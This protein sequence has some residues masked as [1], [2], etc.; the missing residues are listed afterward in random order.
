MFKFYLFLAVVF[1]S[2]SPVRADG[3][4]PAAPIPQ[5]DGDLMP[6]PVDL[7]QLTP[8]PLPGAPVKQEDS[9][10]TIPAA[11]E[12]LAPTATPTP[13]ISSAKKQI[14][15]P[16]VTPMAVPAVTTVE[17][18]VIS[19]PAAASTDAATGGLLD[20]F[21]V[22]EGLKW[23]YDYLKAAPGAG[24]KTRLVECMGSETMANGT[25]RAKFKTTEDGKIVNDTDSIYDNKVEHSFAGKMALK[26]H[27]LLELPGAGSIAHW[28]MV[29]GNGMTYSYKASFGQ[30]KVY[31]KT[32]SDCLIVVEKP[33]K[34]GPTKYYYY[35]KGVGLV[36]LEVYGAGM[37]LS[38]TDSF[39]LIS[40]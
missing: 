9:K 20:Y 24:K 19:E 2:I 13:K 10:E 39:A 29:A 40:Q 30:A 37:K 21:P 5:I 1:L 23:N 4:P 6:P 15:V 12:A 17:T 27:V 28:D 7:N 22:Q 35:A 26:G 34:G 3:T 18:P 8:L 25:L 36:S 32:Y 38:L 31:Q 16:T 11:L 14:Q 33:A